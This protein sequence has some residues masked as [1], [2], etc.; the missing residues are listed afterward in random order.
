M[1]NRST[2]ARRLECGVT[3]PFALALICPFPG[4][5]AAP[6][7]TMVVPAPPL[8]PD[9]SAVTS[10]K[11]A[12]KLVRKRLLV[13]I[14]FFP[15]ELGGQKIRINTGYVTPEAAMSHALLTRM[16]AAYRERDLLDQLEIT[17]DYKGDSIIPTRLLVKASHSQGGKRYERV[18]EVWDCGFCAPLEPLPDPDA[19]GAITA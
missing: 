5:T 16:L 14:H 7:Q 17:A 1:E 9:F 2:T 8:A 18:I 12:A 11:E 13:K 6:A 4:A 3:L 15:V 19:P 10:R